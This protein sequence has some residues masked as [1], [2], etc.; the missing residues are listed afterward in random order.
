MTVRIDRLLQLADL[1][2]SDHSVDLNDWHTCICGWACRTWGHARPDDW[3]QEGC[4]VLGISHEQSMYLFRG[5][6]AVSHHGRVAARRL[7]DFALKV[8]L[9]QEPDRK[10]E[11]DTTVQR[12]RTRTPSMELGPV[13][14]RISESVS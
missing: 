13:F 10:E 11:A 12:V 8:K 1:M 6:E 4:R 2:K 7:R 3:R 5:S 14:L 9:P